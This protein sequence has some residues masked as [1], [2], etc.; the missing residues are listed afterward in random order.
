MKKFKYINA[1][2]IDEAVSALAGAN[3]WVCAGGTDLLGTM[4][5]EILPDDMYPATVVNLKTISPSLEYIKE[6]GVC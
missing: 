3:A 4:R 6:E 5:S 1:T 2:T